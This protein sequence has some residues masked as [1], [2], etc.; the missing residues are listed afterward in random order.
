MKTRDSALLR[1]WRLWFRKVRRAKNFEGIKVSPIPHVVTR[2]SQNQHVFDRLGNDLAGEI[3][4]NKI[5]CRADG[6]H[7]HVIESNQTALRQELI[8]QIEINDDIVKSVV[9][10]D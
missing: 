5:C 10:I 1:R 9:T 7:P 4:D 6:V 3:V 8:G 2:L